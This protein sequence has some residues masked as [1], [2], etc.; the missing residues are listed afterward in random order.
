MS[1]AKLAIESIHV[2][3]SLCGLGYQE[4]EIIDSFNAW[5]F[6]SPVIEVLLIHHLVEVKHGH[7]W[8][9]A[10][11]INYS[12]QLDKHFILYDNGIYDLVGL[13]R[14][15]VGSAWRLTDYREISKKHYNTWED[16]QLVKISGEKIA[17]SG[18][19]SAIQT[20]GGILEA[21]TD[22]WW[23]SALTYLGLDHQT[24]RNEFV[25]AFRIYF[26]KDKFVI[27]NQDELS[28]YE[29]DSPANV[30]NETGQ[31]LFGIGNAEFITK[32]QTYFLQTYYKLQKKLHTSAC[33]SEGKCTELSGR[34]FYP[35]KR[36]QAKAVADA[37]EDCEKLWNLIFGYSSENANEKKSTSSMNCEDEA[38]FQDCLDHIINLKRE[39]PLAGSNISTFSG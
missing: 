18:L 3:K 7:E 14:D 38:A 20:S 31:I 4:K 39:A 5:V 9:M 22:I 16:S 2:N 17:P 1:V 29:F 34:V 11:V 32:W 8:K 21:G 28:S 12:V 36:E 37:K 27:P 23:D 10:T 6:G 30:T 33:F 13:Q 35:T 26:D 24:D 25:K 19:I 15:C